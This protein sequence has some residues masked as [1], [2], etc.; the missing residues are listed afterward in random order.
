[1]RVGVTGV[2]G[3][4]GRR[5]VAEL[6]SLGHEI[7]EYSGDVCDSGS[8]LDWAQPFDVCI[9]AAAIVPTYKVNSNV[10]AAVRVNVIGTINVA[11]AI[12]NV[13]NCKLV[14]IS[15]SHVYQAS[16]KRL[17]ED[18]MIDPRTAYGVTKYQAEQWVAK[19]VHNRLI[20]RVFSFFD[21]EQPDSYLVPALYSR[22]MSAPRNSNLVLKGAQSLRDMASA[23]WVAHVCALLVEKGV[24]GVVNCGTGISVSVYNIANMIAMSLDR[25]DITWVAENDDV[26]DKLVADC[27]KLRSA[28]GDLPPFDLESALRSF[29]KYKTLL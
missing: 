26:F 24:G 23:R 27:K 10:E 29:V 1:M 14:Y 18:D 20:I 12:A 11:H 3:V 28:V 4:L 9:H 15:T 7:V 6:R 5:I 2:R 21:E 13:P 25:D 16:D 19:L 22:M 17:T 8:L